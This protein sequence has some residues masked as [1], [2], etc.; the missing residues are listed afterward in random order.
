MTQKVLS[1][2]PFMRR[3][4]LRARGV[5]AFTAM[6]VASAASAVALL[7]PQAAGVQ[8]AHAQERKPACAALFAICMKRAGAGHAGV[9][10]DMHA[11]A[12]NS[13]VWPAAQDLDGKPY[14]PTPCRP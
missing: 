6:A 10:E 11:Q 8:T 2:R 1:F 7:A 4:F 13:G 14:P 3:R 12:R 9:C 5:G